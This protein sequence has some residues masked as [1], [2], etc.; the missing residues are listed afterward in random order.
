M[1]IRDVLRE[2]KIHPQGFRDS[3]FSRLRGAEH[4]LCAITEQTRN[5]GAKD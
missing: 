2:F 3:P 4:S 5:K 1:K